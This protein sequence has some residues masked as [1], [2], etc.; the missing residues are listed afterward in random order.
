MKT[1]IQGVETYQL[2]IKELQELIEFT[3][4]EVIDLR[5]VRSYLIIN[6]SKMQ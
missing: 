1:K 5:K 3:T 6:R 4:G 2:T